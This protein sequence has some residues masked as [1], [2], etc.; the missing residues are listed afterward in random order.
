[1]SGDG[2]IAW[3]SL[4]KKIKLSRHLRISPLFQV[5]LIRELIK[6]S[7][8]TSGSAWHC[9][10]IPHDP[11]S[12]EFCPQSSEKK[13]RTQPWMSAP[14]MAGAQRLPGDREWVQWEV[15][16]GSSQWLSLWDVGP[17]IF[18][19]GL[20]YYRRITWYRLTSPIQQLLLPS[21]EIHLGAFVLWA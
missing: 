20:V 8:G 19:E 21:V 5:G 10:R 12:V 3:I 1:M 14:L 18:P 7:E 11:V 16:D 4:K 6:P 17:V 2:K 9:G 13:Q 15:A